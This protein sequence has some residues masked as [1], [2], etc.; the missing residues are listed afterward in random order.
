MTSKMM[1]LVK[2]NKNFRDSKQP[3]LDLWGTN[4]ARSTKLSVINTK[5]YKTV[6]TNKFHTLLN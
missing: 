4:D 5:R 3:I 2:G 6:A 1:A